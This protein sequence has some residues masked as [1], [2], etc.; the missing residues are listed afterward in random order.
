MFNG[1]RIMK[2]LRFKKTLALI[3]S[4]VMCVGFT[5]TSASAAESNTGANEATTESV[6]SGTMILSKSGY[7]YND[8][9]YYTFNIPTT[10]WY[11]WTC[12]TSDC[13]MWVRLSG[14]TNKIGSYTDKIVEKDDTVTYNVYFYA[15]ENSVS[16]TSAPNN[17]AYAIIISSGKQ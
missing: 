9:V 6:Y 13:S 1:G 2:V 15:G 8:H 17:G 10:G 14:A 7:I 11:H 3:L 16:I 4:V 5:C 12:G